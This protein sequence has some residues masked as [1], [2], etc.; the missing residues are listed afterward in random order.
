LVLS[1]I[2]GLWCP[3]G[4]VDCAEVTDGIEKP[5]KNAKI[6]QDFLCM[7]YSTILS[8]KKHKTHGLGHL[9]STSHEVF[10]SD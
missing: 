4:A 3:H 2:V 9:G 8:K 5:T 1:F 10:P 7:D 6:K